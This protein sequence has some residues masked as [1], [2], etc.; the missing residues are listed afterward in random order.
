MAPKSLR[1]M[2]LLVRK[3]LDVNWNADGR[4]FSFIYMMIEEDVRSMKEDVRSMKEELKAINELLKSDSFSTETAVDPQHIINGVNAMEIPMQDCY[5]YA[6][7]LMTMHFTREEHT[8][9]ADQ[10]NQHWRNCPDTPRRNATEAAR[11]IEPEDITKSSKQQNPWILTVSTSEDTTTG[12]DGVLP[13]RGPTYRSRV[14]KR[15]EE[16]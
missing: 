16:G 3:S 12:M 5:L 1:C 8:S 13:R 15:F 7:D 2:Q 10:K 4:L 11:V 14:G 9:Q 6:L